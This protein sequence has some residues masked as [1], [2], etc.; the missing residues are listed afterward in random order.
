ME[1]SNSALRFT[2]LTELFFISGLY[3]N[4]LSELNFNLGLHGRVQTSTTERENIKT[5]MDDIFTKILLL[6]LYYI[7]LYYLYH[8]DFIIYITLCSHFLFVLICSPA[9][10]TGLHDKRRDKKV[11]VRRDLGSSS[12]DLGMPSYSVRRGEFDTNHINT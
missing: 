9:E 12:R 2:R 1:P 4:I 3:A 6:Y 10:F 11:P 8:I 5:N 7:I